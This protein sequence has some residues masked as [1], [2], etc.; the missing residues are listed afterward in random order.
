MSIIY[1]FEG[2]S[3]SGKGYQ[4]EAFHSGV[5]KLDRPVLPRCL[6]N[7]AGA[8]S[9]S[10]LEYQAIAAATMG[11]QDVCVDRFLISRWVYR[12]MQFDGGML[13][14]QWYAE[15]ARS[16]RR[17]KGMAVAEACDRM[18]NAIFLHPAVELVVLLPDLHKLELQR[19]QTGKLYPFNGTAESVLY[20]TITYRLMHDP[21]RGI[22]VTILRS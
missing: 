5:M 19:Q 22:Q 17:L 2:P 11:R 4:V 10:F 18:G 7:W 9:S 6:D 21:I 16:F 3:G 8:W 14:P 15:M 20:G 13:R 12:A 1:A